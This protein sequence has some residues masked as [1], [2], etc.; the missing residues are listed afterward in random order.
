MDEICGYCLHH[1]K[2]LEEWICKNPDSECYGCYTEYRDTC[3][4]FE[5][6]SLKGSFS[7]EIKRKQNKPN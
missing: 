6:R 5:D 4:E 1:R 7:I 3:D 2:E